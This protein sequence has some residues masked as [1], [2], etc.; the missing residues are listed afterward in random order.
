MPMC[1]ISRVSH[2]KVSSLNGRRNQ[3]RKKELEVIEHTQYRH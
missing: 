2:F 3:G 1:Q